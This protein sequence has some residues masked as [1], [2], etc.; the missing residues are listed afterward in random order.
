MSFE[1]NY[2]KLFRNKI[3]KHLTL[4]GITVQ[5]RQLSDWCETMEQTTI[6]ISVF[7]KEKGFMRYG[8]SSTSKMSDVLL[9]RLLL[10]KL[11]PVFS[12][13]HFIFLCSI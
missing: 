9:K 10:S 8:F 2:N 5:V 11:K 4:N 7:K 1:T 6:L 12:T 3:A 13:D